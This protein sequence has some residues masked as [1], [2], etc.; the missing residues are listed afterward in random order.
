MLGT[1][2]MLLGAALYI[3]RWGDI[4]PF[5]LN[6][7]PKPPGADDAERFAPEIDK[8]DPVLYGTSSERCFILG[9]N[10]ADGNV[11]HMNSR[12]LC[13]IDAPICLSGAHLENIHTFAP[14][15]SGTCDVHSVNSNGPLERA[16]KFGLNESCAAFR[17][18]HVID[19]YG[20][21]RFDNWDAFTMELGR[22][23]Y[24]DKTH[25]A[26][27]WQSDFAIIVPKYPW[28]WNICHYN[29]IW[30]YIVYVIRNL[31]LF[32]PKSSRKMKSIDVLFR[33]GLAYTGNWPR[34]IREVTIPAL[35]RETKL[36]IR[37][38]KIRYDF[39]RDFQCVKKGIL[40]GDEGRVDAFPYLNDSDIWPL[41][42]L[43][44]DNHWPHIPEQSLWM[45]HT[46]YQSIGLDARIQYDGPG[47]ANF[48]TVPVPPKRMVFLER[49]PRSR[50]K[51]TM[52][53]RVWFQKMLEELAAEHGFELRN[54]RFRKEMSFAMQVTE[55]SDVGVA[56]G[57]HGA[58]MVNTM[59]M[60]TG[61]AMFEIFPWR[62]VR[63]Y[64]A[65]GL[66]SGLRYSYHEPESGV[67]HHCPFDK[68]CFMRYRESVIYL[69]HTDRNTVRER[70]DNAMRYIAHLH[71]RYP[72]G[73]MPLEKQGTLYRVP[74][75]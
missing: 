35:E 63:F 31:E 29:R 56:V 68:F 22:R 13:S 33:S 66:N 5:N 27:T 71:Q 53:G 60:P 38:G 16:D 72:N 59:F 52:T 61:A 36:Q 25:H 74:H 67:D 9:K 40:L 18:R 6:P 65:G 3:S 2:M 47:V 15:G 62:Y 14:R 41:N 20:H 24:Q 7:S 19:I 8:P 30:N 11:W 54:V 75:R 50:R 57:I 12:A 42:A 55:L 73:T 10:N 43:D 28:S 23:K 44:E 32:A 70:I 39:R 4:P 69:T 21:E 48:R 1:L 46:V 37:V 34:G 26:A 49:N 45:R 64:Y 58:N 51:L 17:R